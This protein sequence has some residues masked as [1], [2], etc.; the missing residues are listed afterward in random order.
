M[1]KNMIL[2][3]LVLLLGIV[4]IAG[5]AKKT[6]FQEE[7]GIAKEQAA[8]EQGA[9]ETKPAKE[10]AAIKA[11][12]EEKALREE[13]AKREAENLAAE[14]RA[15]AAKAAPK[16]I[17]EKAN[18]VEAAAATSRE[19]YVFTDVNFD[20]DK[21]N[22]SKDAREILKKYAEWLNKNKDVMIAVEGHCDERGTTEYNLALGERRASA[23]AGFLVDMGID[24][25]RIKTI[26]YGEE[27]PLDQ[28]HNEEAWAKNRRA[29]FVV[30]G[31]K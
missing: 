21:F 6:V 27:L 24:A 5:C 20:F 8:V 15:A 17:Q 18:R 29:H 11:A 7:R 25:K 13:R 1:K 30:S 9:E 10:P 22:L 28:G 14:E 23:A 12:A 2:V 19:P 3:T 31:K 4:F 26:S 16:E